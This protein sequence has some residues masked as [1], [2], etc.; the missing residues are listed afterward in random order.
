MILLADDEPAFQ[1]LTG[2]WLRSLGHEVETVGDGD[3]ARTAFARIAP[4]VVLLDL[5]MPPHHDPEAGLALIP[6]FAPAPVVVMTGHADHALALKAVQAGAWDF[7]AKPVDPDMLQVVV[8]RAVE[9]ARLAREVA[10]L[11]AQASGGEDMGLF[12]V[13]TVM[14]NLRDLIRRVAPTQLPVMVLGPSGTGKELVARAIHNASPRAAKPLVPVHCGAVPA[15]LLE[16]ELFGHLKGSFTGAHA[17]RPGLVEAASG[18]TLFLDEIGEMPAA[19]Q[20][21]L[22]RFLADGSYQPVGAREIRHADVRIVAATH[23]NLENAI[24]DGSF[25][26]DLFYRLRGL[27]LRTP[28]L[29]ERTEDIAMLA[30]LFLGRATNGEAT[31]APD[32][33]TWLTARRWPGNVREL[34]AA[35]ECAA[36]L[37]PKAATGISVSASDLAFAAGEAA[38]AIPVASNQTLEEEVAALERRR[39]SEALDRTGRNHTHAARELGLSRAGLLKKMD[40]MGLR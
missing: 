7:L 30:R 36:A 20:V 31:F 4:D 22:L 38:T 29:D 25:R 3:A 14:A 23:R 34:R 13:S 15:D 9:R 17:D 8:A 35:V 26:E 18:G 6:A 2:Q 39:I 21:K 28:A 5:S 32:A 11:Q 33:L 10:Q 24:A 12:G 19:M 27:V 37:A 40:R 1:R 16:S